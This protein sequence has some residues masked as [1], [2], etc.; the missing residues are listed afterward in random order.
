VRVRHGLGDKLGAKRHLR[1]EE[2]RGSQEDVPK[3]LRFGSRAAGANHRTARGDGPSW[4]DGRQSL[5][6]DPVPL[7]SWFDDRTHGGA[8]QPVI[9]REAQ[10][11]RVSDLEVHD[12]NDLLRRRETHPTVLL[13]H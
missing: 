3:L 13:T 1:V 7:D 4:Q 12:R 5:G 9:S 2:C 6:G 8:Q 11:P 10:G